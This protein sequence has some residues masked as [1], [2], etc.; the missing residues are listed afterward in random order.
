MANTNLTQHEIEINLAKALGWPKVLVAYNVNGWGQNLPL[1]HECDMLVLSK[2]GYLTEI[3]IKRSFEDFKNDFKKKHQHDNSE[4]IKYFYYAV[5]HSIAEKC[6]QYFIEHG[7][8]EAGFYEYFDDG[9]VCN[10]NVPIPQGKKKRK[11]RKLTTEEQ[12]QIARFG[13][14]RAVS[15]REKIIR[16]QKKNS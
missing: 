1:F 10:V 15:L 5:P 12:F 14:M 4:L 3:E 9:W 16:I 6:V 8:Y 13:A 11:F 7:E 2:S